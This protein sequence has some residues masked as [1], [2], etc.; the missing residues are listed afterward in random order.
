MQGN[1]RPRKPKLL[2]GLQSYL[3]HLWWCKFCSYECRW[4][5]SEATYGTKDVPPFTIVAGVPAR[6]VRRRDGYHEGAETE[7][8]L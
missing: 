8:E 4:M 7:Y 2:V 6:F 1:I 5:H 3:L